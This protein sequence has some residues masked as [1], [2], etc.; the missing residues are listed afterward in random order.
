MQFKNVYKNKKILITGL[1]GFKGTW[2]AYWLNK[3]GAKVTGIS[4]DKKNFKSSLKKNTFINKKINIQN[5]NKLEKYLKKIQP[6]IIFHLAAPPLVIDSYEDPIETWKT[7]VIGTANLLEVCKRLNNIKAIIIVTSDKCYKDNPKL[8]RY[9][10]ID[11]LGG[12]DP[13]SSSKAS[14]ELL[15]ESFRLSF[16]NKVNSPK[17]ATVRAGNVIGGGD[18]G[19][20]RII[21][22]IM[23]SIYENK[24]LYIRNLNAIRPWQ[25]VLY[26][27]SGYLLLGQN[28]ILNKNL[29]YNSWNFGPSIKS[30]KSVINLIETLEKK[31]SKVKYSTKIKSILKKESEYLMLDSSLA[32][33][34]LK[35]KPILSFNEAI[36]LTNSWYS[37]F[38]THNKLIYDQQLKDYF[39]KALKRNA[40]WI[41]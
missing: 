33:K 28:L 40:I 10:E 17:I 41:K 20:N 36:N 23:L 24:D 18:W 32:K 7:N 38:Y 14:T 37:E 39:N 11:R 27:L 15:V 19:K 31:L 16:F 5:L 35:W 13:Y 9:K 34:K 12:H 21:P 2:L 3:L 30:K 29:N 26:C 8:L 1:S 22:D 6:E 25:H 4:Y